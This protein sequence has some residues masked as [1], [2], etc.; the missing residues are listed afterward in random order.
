MITLSGVVSGVVWHLFVDAEVETQHP[1]GVEDEVFELIAV[2]EEAAI[3]TEEQAVHALASTVKQVH[4]ARRLGGVQADFAGP[5]VLG[6][7]VTAGQQGVVLFITVFNRFLR[8]V[9]F[10][11]SFASAADDRFRSHGC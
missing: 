1:E 9:L 5:A 3:A 7:Q 11:R 8:L 2:H 10:T 4:D 6:V